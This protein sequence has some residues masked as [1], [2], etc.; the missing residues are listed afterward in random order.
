MSVEDRMEVVEEAIA[1]AVVNPK[2]EPPSQFHFDRHTP[3]GA[4]L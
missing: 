2:R 4:Q 3:I 1:R